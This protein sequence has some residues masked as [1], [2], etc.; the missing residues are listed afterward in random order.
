MN[1]GLRT[2]MSRGKGASKRR[3]DLDSLGNVTAAQSSTEF[4]KQGERGPPSSTLPML[5]L[6]LDFCGGRSI[7]KTRDNCGHPPSRE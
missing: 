4:Y 7:G 6:I 3:A 1:L 2:S 5:S